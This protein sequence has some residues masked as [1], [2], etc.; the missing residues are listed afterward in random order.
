MFGTQAKG[1]KGGHSYEYMR[2]DGSE[3][4]SNEGLDERVPQLSAD[5]APSSRDRAEHSY[6]THVGGSTCFHRQPSEAFHVAQDSQQDPPAESIAESSCL[7]HTFDM[8]VPQDEQGGARRVTNSTSEAHSWT[9][10]HRDIVENV[11]AMKLLI[12]QL[13]KI[14]GEI[15]VLESQQSLARNQNSDFGK[16][17]TEQ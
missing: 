3:D 11:F 15:N 7:R 2:C 6:D 9:H 1:P 13:G 12:A 4:Y 10:E 8:P 5:V 17:A 16:Q 14:T